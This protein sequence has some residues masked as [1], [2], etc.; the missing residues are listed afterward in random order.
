M[1][2]TKHPILPGWPRQMMKHRERCC[3]RTGGLRKRQCRRVALKDA[4]IC[5][6][7]NDR[8]ARAPD[9]S[10]GKPGPRVP[11]RGDSRP[12][13]A[14]KGPWHNFFLQD[15]APKRRTAQ[16]AMYK[17]HRISTLCS[18]SGIQIRISPRCEGG[19]ADCHS[20]PA[21]S[22]SNPTGAATWA[23]AR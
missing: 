23:N 3:R 8:P 11:V 2:F 19:C 17:V 5:V 18:T 22:S 15:A 14:L 12:T 20:I 6:F 1:G 7:L 4:N 13:K 9:Q 16:Q 10:R 21:A